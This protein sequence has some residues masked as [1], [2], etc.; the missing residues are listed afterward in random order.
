MNIEGIQFDDRAGGVE[1]RIKVV[2]GSRSEAIVGSLGNCL[3]IK[4]SDPPEGG[5]ANAAVCALLAK[6]LG[7]PVR[8]VQIIEGHTQPRKKV[9]IQGM[10]SSTARSA[11]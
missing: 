4:V 3:K 7:V 5:K 10:D 2:P 11:L 1:W 6:T 8:D 9:R